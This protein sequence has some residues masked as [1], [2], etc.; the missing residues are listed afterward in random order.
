MG[1]GTIAP[2]L[3]VREGPYKYIYSE[4]DPVQLYDLEKDPDELTNVAGAPAYEAIEAQLRESFEAYW[5]AER[6]VQLTQDVLRSQRQRRLVTDA[7]QAGRYNS[8]DYDPPSKENRRYIRN[9]DDGTSMYDTERK[10]RLPRFDVWQ[11]K[12]K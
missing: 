12:S 2:M 4:P 8:W 11:P 3:M 5:P 7:L 1:E 9:T 6:R 10:A